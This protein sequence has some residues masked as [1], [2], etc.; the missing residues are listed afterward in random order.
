MKI[1]KSDLITF[2]IKSIGLGAAKELIAK[3]INA[4]ALEDKKSYTEK[5]IVKICAKL[6]KEGGLIRVVTQDF[7]V[8]MERLKS[9]EKTL[10]LDNVENHMWNLTDKN[11]YGIVNKAHAKFLGL[12]KEELEGKDLHD[13][14]SVKEA[15]VCI[16]NNKE[17][18]KKKKQSRTEEWVKNRKG[19]T[20]LLS[21]TRTP[22]LD[23][24]GYVE[25]VTCAA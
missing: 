1:K 18:F 17:V 23:N 4:A 22:K 14:I 2:Y 20:R 10:L 24:K 13:I 25:Y 15:S 6:L 11:T 19:E 3:K 7:L 8:Q 21:I 16:A 12:K 9:E 5:E